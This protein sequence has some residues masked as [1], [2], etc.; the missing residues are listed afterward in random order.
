M[1]TL[2]FFRISPSQN[3]FYKASIEKQQLLKQRRTIE[4]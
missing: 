1:K 2:R 3:V 4:I